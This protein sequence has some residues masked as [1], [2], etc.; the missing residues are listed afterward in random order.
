MQLASKT[1]RILRQFPQEEKYAIT[2]QMWRAAIS[3]PSNIAEGS[4]RSSDKEFSNYILI[5][6]GSLAELETQMLLA[7]D[8]GLIQPGSMQE[9]SSLIDELRKMIFSFHRT[10]NASR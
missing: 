10:L 4:Q 5:A 7:Q 6:K 9:L 3:I 8:I 1:H 2:Q